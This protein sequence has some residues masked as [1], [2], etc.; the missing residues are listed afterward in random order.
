MLNYKELRK[1]INDNVREC[2]DVETEIRRWNKSEMAMQ[3]NM[4]SVAY[5]RKRI[6]KRSFG[7]HDLYYIHNR[8]GVDINTLFECVDPEGDEFITYNNRKSYTVDEMIDILCTLVGKVPDS[9]QADVYMR[10]IQV[11]TM[12]A[13]KVLGSKQ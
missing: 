6:G 8:L 7:I 1:K 3:L 10:M 13:R 5:S 2:L 12:E 4:D 9:N 11:F